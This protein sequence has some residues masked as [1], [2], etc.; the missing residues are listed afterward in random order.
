[1]MRGVS[2]VSARV[3]HILAPAGNHLAKD[4]TECPISRR[5]CEKWGL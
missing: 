4:E 1:M 2:L 3:A 5:L